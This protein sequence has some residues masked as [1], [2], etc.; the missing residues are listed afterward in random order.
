MTI[1]MFISG[2]LL[3]NTIAKK[4]YL[5][6]LLFGLLLSILFFIISLF[7]KVSYSFNVLIYYIV[8][9][10]SSMIGSMFQSIKK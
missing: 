1:V 4:K 7:F 8:L 3:S 6:G 2:Y 9:S 5:H 10:L